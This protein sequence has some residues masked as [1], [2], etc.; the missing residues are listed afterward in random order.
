MIKVKKKRR[1]IILVISAILL[2]VYW[3]SL[4]KRLFDKPTST[5]IISQEGFML[6]ARVADDGQWRFPMQ[7]SVPLKFEKAILTFED[8]YFYYHPGVNL[9]SLI[10]AAYQDIKARKI[11]SGGSTISMQLIR[12]SQNYPPRTF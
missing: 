10:R 12:L 2:L 7:D 11:V 6:G 4:P 3:F 5:V 8:Q 1:G 9:V